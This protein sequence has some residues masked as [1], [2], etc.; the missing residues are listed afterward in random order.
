MA[1]KQTTHALTPQP[2]TVVPLAQSLSLPP[3]LLL[4]AVLGF[5]H[6]GWKRP[7]LLTPCAG[8]A[9]MAHSKLMTCIGT[10]PYA[11]ALSVLPGQKLACQAGPPRQHATAQPGE[12]LATT[13][14]C[15]VGTRVQG[16]MSRVAMHR[17]IFQWLT[18]C[19]VHSAGLSV[20]MYHPC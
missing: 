13:S 14:V 12:S 4:L 1:S 20:W 9:A 19:M 6:V 2:K 5:P 10:R 15:L 3:A 17:Q 7:Y 16:V 8:P 11:S 18:Y